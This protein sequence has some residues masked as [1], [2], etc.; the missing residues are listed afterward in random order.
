[1]STKPSNRRPAPPTAGAGAPIS[2]EGLSLTQVQLLRRY[3]RPFLTLTEF[4]E[5]YLPHLGSDE[6]LLRLIHQGRIKVRYT[7]TDMTGQTPPV[8][9]LRDL[10][11]WL[12]AHD[13]SNTQPATDRVAS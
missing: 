7:R 8:V 3:T 11:A 5:E 1:V 2:A 4:R 13:P 9:Y 12:D 10:A 6:Y